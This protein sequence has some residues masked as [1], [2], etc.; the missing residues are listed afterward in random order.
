MSKSVNPD[1]FT[2]QY[3]PDE[4]LK[5]HLEEMSVRPVRYGLGTDRAVFNQD[6]DQ[7]A[8][9]WAYRRIKMLE[10]VVEGTIELRTVGT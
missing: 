2:G 5:A 4:V 8:I 9:L 3:W 10:Q 1:A 7:Q 6:R